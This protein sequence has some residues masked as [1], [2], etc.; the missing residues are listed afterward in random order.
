MQKWRQSLEPGEPDPAS[1]AQVWQVEQGLSTVQV[2]L[3]WSYWPYGH[4]DVEA[5][6]GC[7]G[8]PH[9]SYH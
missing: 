5:S 1:S 8:S 4:I 9:L 7:P 3:N 6:E 2:E